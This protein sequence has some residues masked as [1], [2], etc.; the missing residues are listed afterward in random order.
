[1]LP[2]LIRFISSNLTFRC[3]MI[4]PGFTAIHTLARNTMSKSVEWLGEEGQ[5]EFILYGIIPAQG[6][7]L[8]RC[9]WISRVCYQRCRVAPDREQCNANCDDLVQSCYDS[10]E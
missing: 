10:C 7:C 5:S 1:M 3:Q 4:L 8:S 2:V 6:G 9:V